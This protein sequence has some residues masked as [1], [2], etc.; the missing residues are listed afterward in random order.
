[1][2]KRSDMLLHELHLDILNIIILFVSEISIKDLHSLPLTSHTLNEVA[3][4]YILR[5]LYF[6]IPWES[7]ELFE[8][9]LRARPAYRLGVR[10]LQLHGTFAGRSAQSV[11]YRFLQNVPPLQ[12]LWT[13]DKGVTCNRLPESLS[14]R[15]S[16]M[17]ITLNV[18]VM[19]ATMVL[20]LASLPQLRRLSI[21]C[22]KGPE[23][24]EKTLESMEKIEPRSLDLRGSQIGHQVLQ[25]ILRRSYGLEKLHCNV[26]LL[27]DFPRSP[28]GG[29]PFHVPYGLSPKQIGACFTLIAHT[30]TE[31]NLGNQLLHWQGMTEADSI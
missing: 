26:T 10:S 14:I 9:S 18:G 7:F 23:L 28:F 25:E 29:S 3:S 24:S 15:Q 12:Y 13:N 27:N 8:R 5:R 30:L 16:L 1:M 19:T 17:N 20:Q 6:R 21:R 11:L 2:T 4:S 22:L 31:L